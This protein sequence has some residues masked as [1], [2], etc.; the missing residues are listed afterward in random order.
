MYQKLVNTLG[1][2]LCVIILSLFTC[3][4]VQYPG[5]RY[6]YFLFTLALNGLLFAG[7]RKNRIFF[8]TFIG[9]FFWLGYWL[10]FSYR[11]AFREGKFH[12]PVGVNFNYSGPAYDHALLVVICGVAA[13]LLVSLLREWLAFNY[14]EKKNHIRLDGLFALYKKYRFQIWIGFALLFV[15]ISAINAIL[16]IYQRGAV[17]KTH[18]PYKLGGVFT[19]LLLFGSA[20]ISAIIL[21][22]ELRLKQKLPHIAVVLAL[23][24]TFFSSVSM[25]SRGMILNAC[26]LAIGT[27]ERLK[28]I[29]T[30]P[31]LADCLFASAVFVLLF[32]LSINTVRLMRDFSH[33]GVERS[34]IRSVHHAQRNAAVL[35]LDR[36]VGIEG[37]MAVSS[38]AELGWELWKEAWKERYANY[39]TSFYDRE[40]AASVYVDRPNVNQHHYISLP[41]IIAFLYYP[42]SMAFLFVA[43]IIA[44][45][46]GA[47]I[48]LTTFKLGGANLILTAL[49]SQVV[50]SRYAHFGYVPGQSYLLFGTLGFNV[51]LIFIF[52]RFLVARQ[53][54][55]FPTTVLSSAIGKSDGK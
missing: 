12:E 5:K 47:I 8:D 54:K 46:V 45:V 34:K 10:K 51:L 17:P 23:L 41:G 37:A 22:F 9:L 2:S 33:Y 50:A 25:M 16:G 13:L 28:K 11:M 38:Y 7:F 20:S 30:V 24:E 48:D 42:G 15:A 35:I 53:S 21:E 29:G 44:G 4:L 39:G 27:L 36:W 18:L 40:I 55:K 19:W 6:I 26:A 31:T 1:I 3:A 43:M 14:P 49:L 52:D 32:G